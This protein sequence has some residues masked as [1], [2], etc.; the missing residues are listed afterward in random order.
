MAAG[1]NLSRMIKLF[2]SYAHEDEPMRDQLEVHLAMLKRNGLISS[3]HDRRIIAGAD[4]DQ[5]V[6]QNLEEA[7]VIL[8]LLS[9]HF[10]ASSYC[11]EKESARAL[12][13]H[14]AGTA[15]V[16]PVVLQPCDWLHSPFSR[17]RA[18]P[19]DG[20]PV[21]KYPNLNDA[22]LE[23]ISDIRAAAESLRKSETKQAA[24]PVSQPRQAADA[25]S[26]N[27]RLKRAFSDKEHDT[28]IDDA[29]AYIAKYF[30]SSLGELQERNP[31]TEFRFKRLSE[32]GF[33]AAIYLG[34]AKRTSCHIWLG[35]RQSFAGDIA[36]AAND[37]SAINSVNDGVRI[38][39]D[40][41]QLGL[42]TSGLSYMRTSNDALITPQG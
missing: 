28:F 27:L 23:V 42:K 21:A 35:G 7:D 10:L 31:E 8:L 24:V 20:K 40:G 26:S 39:D 6:D 16:I 41:S 25:R 36:Y 22:F 29:Y 32:T 4:L 34:G 18:T 38:E 19:K 17:L 37:S 3:W 14:Q 1:R 5:T 30:E 2:F 15:I 12:E 9:A 11:Y 13:R 33:T